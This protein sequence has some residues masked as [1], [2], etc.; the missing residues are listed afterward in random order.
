MENFLY[1]L[2]QLSEAS[3]TLLVIATYGPVWF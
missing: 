1:F 3:K 2:V